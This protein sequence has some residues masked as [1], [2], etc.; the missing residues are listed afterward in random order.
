MQRAYTVGA[1]RV[2]FVGIAWQIEQPGFVLTLGHREVAL[3]MR[4]LGLQ[5]GHFT[6]AG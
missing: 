3:W 1:L 6:C 4:C 5:E 2:K